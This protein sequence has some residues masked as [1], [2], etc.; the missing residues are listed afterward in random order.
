MKTLLFILLLAGSAFCASAQTVEYTLQLKS[1]GCQGNIYINVGEPTALDKIDPAL[2]V[3]PNPAVDVLNVPVSASGRNASVRL[4][5]IDGKL[6]Q[7][8]TVSGGESLCRFVLTNYPAG[9]YFV[10]VI[11]V[12]KTVYRI[13]KN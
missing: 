2:C 1:D 4:L 9:I 6:L 11:G 10:Q 8:K 7:Q 13:V 5:D 12:K 3:Y